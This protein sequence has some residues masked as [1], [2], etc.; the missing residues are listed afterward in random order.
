MTAVMFPDE[1]EPAEIAA[2]MAVC[3]PCPVRP[4]CLDFAIANREQFGVWGGMTTRERWQEA[5]RRAGESSGRVCVDCGEKRPLS[6]FGFSGGRPYTRCKPHHAEYVKPA[7]AQYRARKRRGETLEPSTHCP[8]GH[9]FDAQNTYVNP[10]DG[11]RRCRECRKNSAS[12]ENAER[13][14]A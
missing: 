11:V 3:R 4:A 6:E 9:P 10:N 1:S 7:A 14:S 5:R 8:K 2:A 12:R 13:E